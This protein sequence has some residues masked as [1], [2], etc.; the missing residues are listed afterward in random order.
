MFHL[1]DDGHL[2]YVYWLQLATDSPTLTR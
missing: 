1:T 2:R